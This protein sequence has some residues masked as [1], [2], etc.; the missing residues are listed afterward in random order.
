MSTTL[1]FADPLPPRRPAPATA[2]RKE[3]VGASV[4]EIYGG[5]QLPVLIRLP[6][7]SPAARVPLPTVATSDLGNA[8]QPTGDS[9]PA[10]EPRQ[11]PEDAKLPPQHLRRERRPRTIRRPRTN[12]DAT[13]RD[14]VNGDAAGWLRGIGQLAMAAVLAGV[15]LVIVITIKHWNADNAQ[16]RP[17]VTAPFAEP[18]ELDFGGPILEPAADFRPDQGSRRGLPSVGTQ[19]RTLRGVLPAENSPPSLSDNLR[20]AGATNTDPRLMRSVQ[21]PEVSRATPSGNPLVG[22]YPS[23]D[24]VEPVS[25]PREAFSAGDAA[26]WSETISVG[27]QRN[28]ARPPADPRTQR[29]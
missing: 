17:A 5:E 27:S 1:P 11:Q 20:P 23:T 7:L 28:A 26:G 14:A 21:T 29:R 15:L 13:N 22:A 16:S 8:A 25:T 10:A 2:R 19:G 24:F 4:S 6:D 18:P 12:R 9:A 3:A